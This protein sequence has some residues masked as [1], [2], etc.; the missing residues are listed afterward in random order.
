MKYKNNTQKS[1][2]HIAV[3]KDNLEIVKLLLKQPN[4]DVNIKTITKNYFQ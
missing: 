1:A 3:E 2:L 4:I